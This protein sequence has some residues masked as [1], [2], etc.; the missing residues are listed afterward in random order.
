M[1]RLPGE[2]A[3]AALRRL[4]RDPDYVRLLETDAGQALLREAQRDAAAA[5]RDTRRTATA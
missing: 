3:D 1:T 2:T 5:R 4:E